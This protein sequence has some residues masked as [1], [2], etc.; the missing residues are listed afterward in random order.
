MVLLTGLLLLVACGGGEDEAGGTTTAATNAGAE[1]DGEALGV[2]QG[3]GPFGQEPL[4][5]PVFGGPLSDCRV[6][7]AHAFAESKLDA[8]GDVACA[9]RRKRRLAPNDASYAA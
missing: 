8:S 5:R 9:P 2:A 4:P 6:L 3:V 7:K 1:K